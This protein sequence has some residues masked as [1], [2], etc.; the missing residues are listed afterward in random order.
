MPRAGS[1]DRRTPAPALSY[2]SPV[3]RLLGMVVASAVLL[4][5]RVALCDPVPVRHTEGLVHGFLVL[6][7]LEGA[8]LA[9]GELI[10]RARGTRVTSRL[11]FRF[12]DGSLH[13]E[14]AVYSQRQTFRLLTYRLIQR[15]P[16]FPRRLDMSID[17]PSGNVTVRHTDDDGEKKVESERLDLPLDL[18]NGMVSTLL[19]NVRPGAL[20]KTVGYLAAT[21][22]PRL[23]KLSIAVAGEESFF[24]G[25]AGRKATHYVLKVEIGGLAGVVAPLV[26]K[27]PPDSHVWIL[28]GEAPA[29]LKAEQPFYNGGPVWRIELASPVWPARRA[30]G[31]E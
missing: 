28:P 2:N 24:A 15:G 23:V 22:K 8:A 7:T 21:P 30:K 5:P 31:N 6:R 3:P 9:R 18:A 4:V 20:P 10:Q 16:S 13:D 29:F 17:A 14:T 25:G 26:G 12:K 19:K 27:E 11:V 1:S